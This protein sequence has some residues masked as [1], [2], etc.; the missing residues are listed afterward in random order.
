MHRYSMNASNK[1]IRRVRM[2]WS[3][4]GNLFHGG[5]EGGPSIPIDGSAVEGPA[6]MQLL[7]LS[8]AGCMAVD[9]R[10]ILEKSRVPLSDLEIEV[11]GERAEEPPRKYVRIEM[12]CHLEGP[13]PEDDA[14]V[15]RAIDLSRDKYCSVI[16][17]LDPSIDL[18]VRVA[19]PDAV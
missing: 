13:G 12:I 10:M 6:P 18:K 14:K 8:A 15:Q 3:G 5:P 4:Q 11:I 19:T 7:L 1:N 17:T 9:I 2:R 16:H